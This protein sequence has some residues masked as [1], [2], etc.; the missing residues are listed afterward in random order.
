[1]LTRTIVS[2]E[3]AQLR[4]LKARARAEGIS[5]AELMRRLVAQELQAE[6]PP[7]SVPASAFERI[8]AM[9]ASGRAD[10]GDRHDALV[11]DAIRKE[12]DR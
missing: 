11:A 6:R 7:T 4:A 12:H 1:M 5:V 8:V 9:G 3:R 2:L 10:V